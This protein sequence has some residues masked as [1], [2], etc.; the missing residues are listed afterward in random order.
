M[1][2]P[3]SRPRR[4]R[5]APAALVAR[6][7]LAIALAAIACVV[8]LALLPEPDGAVLAVQSLTL[9]GVGIGARWIHLGSHRAGLAAVAA[10]V[11]QC[12][13]A[14]IVLGLVRGPE[15]VALVP[16]AQVA[17]DLVVAA[18]FM[19]ALRRQVGPI[20]ISLDF[21][22]LWPLVARARHL[23]ASAL[24]GIAIYSTGLVVLRLSRGTTDAGYFTAAYTL[25]TFFLNVGAMYNLSLLPTLT[26]LAA[27]PARQR[28]LFQDAVIHVLAVGL[29]LA[30]GGAMLAGP[31]VGLVYGTKFAAASIAFGLLVWSIPLNLLR[32]VPL[33]ALMA[34][35]E[36]R[37][38]FRVTVAGAVVSVGLGLALVPRFG[39]AGAGAAA[40]HAGPR[41]R[42]DLPEPVS[43]GDQH[44]DRRAAGR[45]G[46]RALAH[47]DVLEGR[48]RVQRA[49]AAD[50]RGGHGPELVQ[51]Q[52]DQGESGAA[53][54]E[55]GGA[56][57]HAEPAAALHP[58]QRGEIGARRRGGCRVERVHPVHEGHL[59]A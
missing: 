12:V 49:P 36:E 1:P 57:R 26:R 32:D 28:A 51:V 45:G 7:L 50:G 10:T 33:M 37:L 41:A 8:G 29:P 9:L 54:E 30:V 21:A 4:R 23:V 59:T 25:V 52:H 18:I 31:V 27:E 19:V 44:R 46:V 20:R 48:A 17:G 42:A 24:L 47:A 15:H 55:I 2:W 56:E 13:M 38:V 34:A 58:Q 53:D 6:T 5:A 3:A 40:D 39:L 35:G 16:A 14:V 43:R 11:G 22:P